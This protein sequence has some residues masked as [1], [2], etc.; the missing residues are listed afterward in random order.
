L[1]LTSYLLTTHN[2]AK[3]QSQLS[4]SGP[5]LRVFYENVHQRVLDLLLPLGIRYR[6]IVL[7]P[8]EA[9]ISNLIFISLSMWM[10]DCVNGFD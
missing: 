1:P 5:V 10:T 9:S 3:K 2:T 8:R 6:S 4:Q 7:R